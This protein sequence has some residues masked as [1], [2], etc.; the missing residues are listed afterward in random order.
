MRY[1]FGQM[2]GNWTF[3]NVH[4]Y[5][6]DPRPRYF[7]QL[8]NELFFVGLLSDPPED[9]QELIELLNAEAVAKELEIS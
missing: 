8:G 3:V 6:S 7:F 1:A 2:I 9:E 4:Y 5:G